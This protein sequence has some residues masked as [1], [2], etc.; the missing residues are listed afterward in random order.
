MRRIRLVHLA[1]G[2]GAL[3]ALAAIFSIGRHVYLA[4]RIAALEEEFAAAGM[5]VDAA[6]IRERFAIP[7]GARNA[8]AV[9]LKAFAD[10]DSEAEPLEA[11]EEGAPKLLYLGYRTAEVGS[12]Y[13]QA[14]I[15][16]ATK[17]LGRHAH[18]F[19]TIREAMMLDHYAAPIPDTY[20]DI[21]YDAQFARWNA[22]RTSAT[23]T[24]L[25]A[26]IDTT[27]GDRESAFHVIEG[28][29]RF[30]TVREPFMMG[31]LVRLSTIVQ[32]T[33]IVQDVL[34]VADWSEKQLASFQQIVREFR[35][36]EMR[37]KSVAD[38]AVS[39][40]HFLRLALDAKDTQD[41]EFEDGPAWYL[42]PPIALIEW[43]VA[44]EKRVY[45]TALEK[46]RIVI[47]TDPARL[48][49]SEAFRSEWTLEPEER[50]FLEERLRG[51][52]GTQFYVQTMLTGKAR[53][54]ATFQ[55][56]EMALAV[57]RYRLANGSLPATLDALLP[58]YLG[59]LPVD[60]FSGTPPILRTSS[61]SFVVYYVDQDRKDDGGYDF[62]KHE[63]MPW[64]TGVAVV[65]R[66]VPA[67]SIE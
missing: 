49:E 23:M 20:E 44:Y 53:E 18:R 34:G 19:P 37:S 21:D 3:I 63:S 33:D 43:L 36:R 65:R 15:D 35:L 42:R 8:A 29:T 30:E 14:Q 17:Y 7:P 28:M 38:T 59:E 62:E 9:Y 66:T 52:E 11:D 16:L 24:A 56:L 55:A 2:F 60:P 50:S 22:V 67:P 26:L 61:D 4:G 45:L 1:A 5:G 48:Y 12:P 40:V 46:V 47:Q 41:D 25:A 6:S 39:E 27:R 58:K 13:S 57:E 54:L 64:D 31:D 32:F 51:L 10:Y